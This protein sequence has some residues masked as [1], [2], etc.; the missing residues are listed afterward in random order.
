E[1][2]NACRVVGFGKVL[3][4]QVALS[5]AGTCAET[6]EAPVL[7]LVRKAAFAS[8]LVAGAA[9]SAGEVAL[10]TASSDAVEQSQRRALRRLQNLTAADGHASVDGGL[11]ERALSGVS[12]EDRALTPW[13]AHA[14]DAYSKCAVLVATNRSVLCVGTEGMES[15]WSAAGAGAGAGAAGERALGVGFAELG[16]AGVALALLQTDAREAFTAGLWALG[17]PGAAARRVRYDSS[18]VRWVSFAVLGAQVTALELAAGG[19]MTLRSYVLE[20]GAPELE[21]LE[22]RGRDWALFGERTFAATLGL[23]DAAGAAD[24]AR[25]NAEEA[26][27]RFSRVATTR[28]SRAAV[29]AAVG[30][31][32]TAVDALELEVLV[33]AAPRAARS[34]DAAAGAARSEDAAAGAARSEDA[35]AG[36][37]LCASAALPR[38]LGLQPGFVSL[39]YLRGAAFGAAGG[40]ELWVVGVL[41]AVFEMRFE[42]GA[43]PRAELRPAGSS[44]LTERS[45]VPAEAALSVQRALAGQAAGAE[46]APAPGRGAVFYSFDRRSLEYRR[47]LAF[48]PG[49]ARVTP[50][51][52]ATGEPQLHRGYLVLAALLRP[53]RTAGDRALLEAVRLVVEVAPFRTIGRGEAP[54]GI[55][56]LGDGRPR[57][58]E[59]GYALADFLG[60]WRRDGGEDGGATL[61]AL[62]LPATA[63]GATSCA[64]GFRETV[65]D[66]QFFANGAGAQTPE[67]AALLVGVAAAAEPWL[68]VLRVGCAEWHAADRRGAAVGECVVQSTQPL[69]HALQGVALRHDACAGGSARAV[70]SFSPGNLWVL[71]SLGPDGALVTAS[72]ATPNCVALAHGSALELARRGVAAQDEVL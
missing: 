71:F 31:V 49:F 41:G 51:M 32:R 15:L 5:C 57:V 38:A 27:L 17:A 24:A 52:L 68:L 33:C 46:P 29:A 25:T 30:A 35:A 18:A 19:R 11:L 66:E 22:A 23:A 55:D 37:A 7:V 10:G 56:A 14:V 13:Q 64:L 69:T 54:L 65:V 62:G 45:F 61:T 2:E 60:T 43:A 59:Y 72:S 34:E 1:A 58:F 16:G 3:P 50:A 48:L 67:A 63:G 9:L 53:L 70:L 40:E 47:L 36:A 21:L 4:M 28:R 8:G 42:A 12:E 39:A 6:A 44:A 20:Q 26:W